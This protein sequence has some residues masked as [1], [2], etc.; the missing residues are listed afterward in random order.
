MIDGLIKREF[1]LNYRSH[2]DQGFVLI[3]KMAIN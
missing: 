2:N 1:Y 3:N